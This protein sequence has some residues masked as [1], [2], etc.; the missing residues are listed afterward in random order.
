M[1]CRQ[2]SNF[3]ANERTKPPLNYRS[4]FILDLRKHLQTSLQ[5]LSTEAP[6]SVPVHCLLLLCCINWIKKNPLHQ[7]SQGKCISQLDFQDFFFLFPHKPIL[8]LFQCEQWWRFDR[9]ARET[10]NAISNLNKFSCQED[11]DLGSNDHW[12]FPAKP[13]A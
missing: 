5:H 4:V 1:N 8:A 9:A 10:R 6:F 13:W 7:K 2:Q 11:L 12:D 3:G